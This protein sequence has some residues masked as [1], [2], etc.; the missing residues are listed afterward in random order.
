MR[1]FATISHEARAESR[2]VPEMK[3]MDYQS[4]I[5]RIDPIRTRPATALGFVAVLRKVLVIVLVWVSVG[6]PEGAQQRSVDEA[7]GGYVQLFNGKDIAG[8][9]PLDGPWKVQDNAIFF[10]ELVSWA[11]ADLELM[12][13]AVVIPCDFDLRLEWKEF[14]PASVDAPGVLVI[15]TH[16]AS[17]E[18]VDEWTGP[19][20]CGC[21]VGDHFI[22]LVTTKEVTVPIRQ[23]RFT[24]S[25]QVRADARVPAGQWN[26]LRMQCKG[27]EFRHWLNGKEILRKHL[28]KETHL[29]E[30][31]T[32]GSLLKQWLELKQQGF[33]LRVDLL[34]RAVALR[35]ISVRAIKDDEK[36]D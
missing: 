26:V 4:T 14:P 20:Y 25:A 2:R 1:Y 13:K 30:S 12:C 23:A 5:A 31:P 3:T 17:R 7:S 9:S 35:N 33:H 32:G 29:I 19:L 10:P 24:A 27:P 11:G 18:G 28:G 8:W 15:G 6:R 36:F 22:Q 16:R 34:G 21:S